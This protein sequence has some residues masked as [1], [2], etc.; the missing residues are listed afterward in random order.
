MHVCVASSRSA[1]HCCRWAGMAWT[2]T[3]S[4]GCLVL[5]LVSSSRAAPDMEL[6]VLNEIASVCGAG[7]IFGVAGDERQRMP[8]EALRDALAIIYGGEFGKFQGI[9]FEEVAVQH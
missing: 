6:V 4:V 7:W 8:V 1:A 3:L 5:L 9:E 2:K